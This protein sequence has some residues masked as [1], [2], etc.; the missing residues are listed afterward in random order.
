MRLH[1]LRRN[2]K[3]HHWNPLLCFYIV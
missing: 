2:K 3:S 1:F